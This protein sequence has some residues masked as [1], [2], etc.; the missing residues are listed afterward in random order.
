VIQRTFERFFRSFLALWGTALACA[1]FF[2]IASIII[3]RQFNHTHY[4]TISLITIGFLFILL[5]AFYLI[6]AVRIFAKGENGFPEINN[7]S[8]FDWVR[9]IS[10]VL[11]I[12]AAA[13]AVIYSMRAG[14]GLYATFLTFVALMSWTPILPVMAIDRLSL[15]SAI[16]ALEVSAPSFYGTAVIA[17]L[18]FLALIAF[19]GL[20]VLTCKGECWGLMEGGIFMFPLLGLFLFMATNTMALCSASAYLESKS[21][22]DPDWPD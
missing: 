17:S 8:I 15:T 22:Q 21:K 16:R 14:W 4:E 2:I 12:L 13:A 5:H 11:L 6:F 18:P 19:F 20:P 10:S 9:A 1:V 3:A 7:Y